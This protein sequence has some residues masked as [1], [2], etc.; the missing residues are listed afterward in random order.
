MC[1]CY[2]LPPSLV[3]FCFVF[4]HLAGEGGE[5][6]RGFALFLLFSFFSF[7]VGSSLQRLLALSL[8]VEVTAGVA[9]PTI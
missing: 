1:W 8:P 7:M 4:Q 5:R 6:N 3:F 2:V 9:K